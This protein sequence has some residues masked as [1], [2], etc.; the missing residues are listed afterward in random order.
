MGSFIVLWMLYIA[1]AIA[2]LPSWASAEP[3]CEEGAITRG[4]RCLVWARVLLTF[5]C[6]VVWICTFLGHALTGPS[7]ITFGFWQSHPVLLQK[8]LLL[9]D[10]IL[11]VS[12]VF[13]WKAHGSGKRILHVAAPIM[14]AMSAIG[15]IVLFRP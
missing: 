9:A 8:L 2:V 3:D 13:A 6:A 5:G 7:G 14:A 10:S 12:V 4:G 15:S 1:G 11:A